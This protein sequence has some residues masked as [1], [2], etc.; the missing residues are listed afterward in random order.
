MELIS[1]M[2]RVFTN[3]PEDQGSLPLESYQRLKKRYLMPRSLTLN[4]KRYKSGVKWTDPGNSVAPSTTPRYSSNWKESLRVVLDNGYQ[5]YLLY[6]CSENGNVAHYHKKRIYEYFVFS[7]L[8]FFVLS[9][10]NTK[11]H[12]HTYAH[13]HTHTHT[14]THIYIY[15]YIY[16]PGQKYKTALK[17]EEKDIVYNFFK[18]WKSDILK[19]RHNDN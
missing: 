4:I 13:R 17:N 6:M 10:S 11:M 9:F 3:S 14:H 16:T 12:T 19:I 1:L 2:A 7:Y 8:I 18:L 5:F 15:I